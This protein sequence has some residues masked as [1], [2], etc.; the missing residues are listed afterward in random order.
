MVPAGTRP[1]AEEA[2]EAP[3]AS[4]AVPEPASQGE[5]VE[6]PRA[7]GTAVEGRLLCPERRGADVPGILWIPED[8]GAG[9]DGT[10]RE[11][12]MPELL[13][14]HRPCAV[15]VVRQPVDVADCHL[16]LCWLRDRARAR[17]IASDQ[18]MV[19]GEGV[20]ANLAIMLACH[21]RDE[22]HVALSWLLP[23]YPSLGAHWQVRLSGMTRQLGYRGLPRATTVVGMDDFSRE[24][25]VAFVEGMRA[26][27]A[28]VDLH[29]YRGRLAGTGMRG[30][31]ASLREARSF[32]LR[33]FDEAVA[34]CRA[35][36][37]RMRT[38]DVPSVG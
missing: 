11:S 38:L 13:A 7:D 16:A 6:I 28:D 1:A 15:L 17:G 19:G 5:R 27:G 32:L 2:P 34:T 24:T 8:D 9:V 26:D 37:P 30:E 20:G 36:Q 21:E 10:P 35:G 3:T 4:L 22:G 29:M 12:A 25:T 33:Q 18:L 31:T 14:G 23:L